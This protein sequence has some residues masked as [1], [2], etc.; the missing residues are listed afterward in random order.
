MPRV[1]EPHPEFARRPDEEAPAPPELRRAN[2]GVAP[3]N[4]ASP[5]R[6]T[7]AREKNVRTRLKKCGRLRLFPNIVPRLWESRSFPPVS[8][9]RATAPRGVQARPR[10]VE[11]VDGSSSAARD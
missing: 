10:G 2:P 3:A 11:R 4:L 5:D 1:R 6:A 8:S 9:A 7:P